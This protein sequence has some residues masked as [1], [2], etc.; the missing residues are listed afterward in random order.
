MIFLEKPKNYSTMRKIFYF[1]LSLLL[2]LSITSES[3]AQTSDLALVKSVND[4]TP[5]Q[6]QVITYTLVVS[7]AG[8]ND[9][10]FEVTD[11]LPAGLTFVTGS[12]TGR[13]TYANSAPSTTG[14]KWQD[15][16]IQNGGSC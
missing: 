2:T 12:M 7:N 5:N 15:I 1:L 3:L 13:G 16:T 14:L 8:P 6:G 10:N 11:V 9:A 4:N